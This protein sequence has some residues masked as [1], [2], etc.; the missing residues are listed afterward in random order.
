MD[1]SP[2]PRLPVH[3]TFHTW[4]GE[5]AHSGRAAYFIRLFGCPIQCPWCDAAGTWHPDWIPE[6]IDRIPVSEL[7]DRAAATRPAFVVITG[8]EPLIHDLGPLTRELHARGL[9]VHLETSGAF[10]LRGTFDWVTVSP[11]WAA[12]PIDPCLERANELKLIVED[13]DSIR[14]WMEV[15]GDRSRAQWI[16]LQ[17]EW[18][19]RSDATVL[20]AISDW[21]RA[22]GDPFRAT[23][24]LHKLY[25]VDETDRGSRPPAPLGGNPGLGW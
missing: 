22:H 13:S 2:G 24:Q 6:R 7:A 15:L 3:E 19:R 20:N 16:W 9:P 25:R 12:P 8:G 4:Q 21:I 23:W 5:G 10:P 17:P 14:R 11:K 1:T 18:S